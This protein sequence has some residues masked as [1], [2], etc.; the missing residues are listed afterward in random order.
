MD[1]A[2]TPFDVADETAVERAYEIEAA[3]VAA[4]LPDFP[5]VCRQQFMGG[6]RHPWPGNRSHHALAYLDGTPAGYV[7]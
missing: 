5:P 4:D 1:I 2:V 3:S 7:R 6:M